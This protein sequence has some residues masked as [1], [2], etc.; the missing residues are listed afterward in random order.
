MKTNTVYIL[1]AGASHFACFPLASDLRD[2]LEKAAGSREILCSTIKDKARADETARLCLEVVDRI[3][4][5]LSDGPHDIELILT[6]VDLANLPG[7]KLQT[8]L[9]LQDFDLKQASRILAQLIARTFQNLSLS[10][11]GHIYEQPPCEK[12]E[13]M[14]EVM[15]AWAK[16]IRPGDTI[17]TFN[18]DMLHEMILWNARKWDYRGGYGFNT[19]QP[20]DDWSLVKVL[21]LH[22]SCNW[23]LSRPQDTIPSLD[24]ND[25]YFRQCSWDMPNDEVPVPLGSTS[26][27]GD[28]LI[29][30]SYMKAPFAKS[31]LV[32]VWM[33]AADSVKNAA[34]VMVLGYSLPVADAPTRTML[35]IAL[36]ENHAL[37]TIQVVLSND[38]S[39]Y[40]RWQDFC[41][42]IGKTVQP[43]YKKFEEF[44]LAGK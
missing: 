7:A 6:L 36:S 44:V 31:A 28:S 32:P 26:D 13:N 37:Q 30:P 3:G 19:N 10:A 39:A 9:G 25:L 38:G 22:G 21:K 43:I 33:Q 23:S 12:C 5:T 8:K 41:S 35:S 14:Q 40:G 11:A 18:W 1:G 27:F 34:K 20:F 24:D 16:L 42:S 29:L 15:N 2:A 4:R 17:I